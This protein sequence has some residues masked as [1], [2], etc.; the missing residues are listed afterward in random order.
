MDIGRKHTF[1]IYILNIPILESSRI[2]LSSSNLIIIVIEGPYNFFEI[3][4]IEV[5]WFYLIK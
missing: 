2:Y 4:D 5:Y 3:L 1:E